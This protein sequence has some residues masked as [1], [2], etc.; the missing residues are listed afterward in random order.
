[1]K[2]L[3]L[4]AAVA[5]S[6]IFSYA[7][8]GQDR[9]VIYKQGFSTPQCVRADRIDSISFMKIEGDVSVDLKVGDYVYDAESKTGTLYL[10][11]TRSANC[12]GFQCEIVTAEQFDAYTEG[13]QAGIIE[14]NGG[15]LYYE[16]FPE[17]STFNGISVPDGED[18]YVV[19]LAYDNWGTPCT[20]TKAKFTVPK[21]PLVGSPKVDATFSDITYKGFKVTI[22]PNED[23]SSF[24]YLYAWKGQLALQSGMMGGLENYLNSFFAASSTKEVTFN[25]DA[26]YYEPGTEWELAVLP[27]D[28]EGRYDTVQWFYTKTAPYGDGVTTPS[29]DITTPKYYMS[30]WTGDN[31]LPVNKATLRVEFTPNSGCNCYR[32][33]VWYKAD[34]DKDSEAI[35]ASL[36]TDMDPNSW[37]TSYYYNIEPSYDEFAIEPN[38][39]IVI[40]AV[41]KAA[42][43]TWGE[44]VVINYTT[45]ASADPASTSAVKSAKTCGIAAP[46][47]K[48]IKAQSIANM[49]RANNSGRA[50]TLPFVMRPVQKSVKGATSG[51]TLKVLDLSK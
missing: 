30:Q 4:T 10:S 49:Q 11:A 40:V 31:G 35:I 22:T 46:A 34:F 41:P 2:K 32:Y 21:I 23:V 27:K 17:G 36:A 18:Y 14:E 48:S 16:D 51:R 9:V 24:G 33:G 43:K 47:S 13:E 5:C 6:A 39:D 28:V 37:A 1:M 3:I 7:Q 15:D 38:T 19:A 50:T 42:D 29:L 20:V 45:P 26:N 12:A 25:G 44:P 8:T